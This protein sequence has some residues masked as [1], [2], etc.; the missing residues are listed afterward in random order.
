MDGLG[1]VVRGPSLA[2]RPAVTLHLTTPWSLTVT[3]YADGW[4]VALERWWADAEGDWDQDLRWEPRDDT[5]YTTRAEAEVACE[6]LTGA[7]THAYPVDTHRYL[8]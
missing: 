6:L 4:R 5:V 8:L 2:E 3:P 1:S 7:K